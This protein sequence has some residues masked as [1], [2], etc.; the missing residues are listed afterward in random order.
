MSFS[1]REFA[2]EVSGVV[3]AAMGQTGSGDDV[4]AG[5]RQPL[6][7]IRS[8]GDGN[9]GSTQQAGVLTVG[10]QSDSPEVSDPDNQEEVCANVQNEIAP[11]VLATALATDTTR[12]GGT[13][14]PADLTRSLQLN[15]IGSSMT[16]PDNDPYALETGICEM[17]IWGFYD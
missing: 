13:M 4:H 11:L 8:G 7:V 16:D 2:E 3:D 9:Q 14:N 5:R 15:S 12:C 1:I 17:E 6:A 10:I